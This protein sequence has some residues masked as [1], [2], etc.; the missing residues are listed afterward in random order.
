MENQ[1]LSF[2]NDADVGLL[3]HETAHQWFGDAV[4]CKTWED[5]WLNEG[6]ATYV[7]DR[8]IRRIDG[9]AAFD[10]LVFDQEHD[11]TSQLDGAVHAPPGVLDTFPNDTKRGKRVLDG[12]LVYN[13]G[14]LVLHMLNFVLG[15]DTMFFHAL[16][17]YVT[18]PHRYSVVTTEDLRSSVEE[19]SGLDLKWFF[20]EW[21]Y[22]EGYPIYSLA[23]SQYDSAVSL[24]ISQTQSSAK[25]PIFRMPIE[26]R[27][28]GN[29]LDT[30]VIVWNDR[31]L[32]S[33]AFRFDRAVNHIEFDPHNYLIDG[34]LP[35]TLGVYRHEPSQSQL[36]VKQ[37]S[38]GRFIF[39]LPEN[40]GTNLLIYAT[41]GELVKREPI[42][43]ETQSIELDLLEL[44]NGAYFAQVG[45]QIAGFVIVR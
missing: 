28:V 36:T 21:V 9:D 39:T 10:T 11:V 14:G 12:R 38:G 30:A 37:G 17:H 24:A 42:V 1:T 19:W 35:R 32:R 29:E 5:C 40:A 8:F 15:S 23:W 2:C 41:N 45:S 31:P 13:K 26:L 34:S 27:F 22:A 43:R 20:D 18:G 3:A 44:S 16:R 25:S 6:F 33:Y 4:T 7:T